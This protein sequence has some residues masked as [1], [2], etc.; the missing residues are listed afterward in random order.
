MTSLATDAEGLPSTHQISSLLSEHSQ[1]IQKLM[2]SVESSIPKNSI[3]CKYDNI[4]FL[5]YILSFGTAEKAKDAVLECFAFRQEPRWV[6]LIQEIKDDTYEENDFVKEMAKWQVAAP[7]DGI[8]VSGGFCVVIRGGMSDQATMIDRIPQDDMYYANMAYRE[9]AFQKCDTVTRE[10]GILAK[11]VMFFDM[12]GSKLS[13]M[14]DR[15]MSDMYA[16]I[17]KIAANVYPQLQEKTC[18]INAPKWMGWVISLFKKLLPVKTMEKFELFSNTNDLW[19]SEWAKDR[20]VQDNAPEFMGG[21]VKDADLM[22]QL[23]GAMRS[24][25][26]SPEITIG[27]RSFQTVTID[28]PIASAQIEYNLIVVARGINFSAEFIEGTGV[29]L[30]QC[31]I[32]KSSSSAPIVLRKQSKLKAETGCAKG[33]WSLDMPGIVKVKFDNQHSMLRSKTVKYTI[34]VR[35]IKDGPT[36]AAAA[37]WR[38]NAT[39][40]KEETKE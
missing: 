19:D 1:E 20:L 23:T 37:K 10:T 5:R 21:K 9:M 16:D 8:T 18:L 32:P 36:G 12:N 26:P 27:A 17:S 7:M 33:V 39:R 35:D 25:A 30:E 14:M 13:D 28:V 15:R 11:Q 34:E 3:Y 6:K 4:F 29:G 2:T 22:P 31:R 38:E 40:N 24:Y